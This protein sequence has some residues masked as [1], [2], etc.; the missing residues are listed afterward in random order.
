MGGWVGGWMDG[1]KEVKAGLRIAYSTCWHKKQ[2]Y[3]TAELRENIC[4]FNFIWSGTKV[5]NLYI[6]NNID[7]GPNM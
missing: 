1:R 2:I 6:N 4:G 7:I 5:Q 3:T